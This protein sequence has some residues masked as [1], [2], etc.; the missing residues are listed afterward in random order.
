M[1][2]LVDAARDAA[3]SSATRI[4]L[5]FPQRIRTRIVQSLPRP[6][7]RP[8][9]RAVMLG[10]PDRVFLEKR[11][12]PALLKLDLR[13][14]LLIGVAYYTWRYPAM[15]AR[16]G[17]ETWTIDIDPIKSRW[18]SHG[19]HVTGDAMELLRYFPAADL[20]L[21]VFNGVLGYGIDD[22]ASA[23]RVFRAVAAVLKPGGLL[24]L[25]WNTDKHPG[26]LVPENLFQAY[27]LVDDVSHIDVAGSDFVYDFF[28]RTREL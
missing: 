8:L 22:V 10:L 21:V 15:F 27:A 26:A 23:A 7:A 19:R 24:V 11:I 4:K 9:A 1:R 6:L 28:E 5:F 25:G 17:V 18:G 16:R 2:R 20:D 12:F 13:R 14:A 3:A